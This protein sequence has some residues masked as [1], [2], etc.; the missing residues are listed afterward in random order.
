[1]WFDVPGAGPVLQPRVP[2][3]IFTGIVRI[4]A[5]EAAVNQPVADLEHIAPPARAP[6]GIAGASFSKIA[7]AIS[8]WSMDGILEHPSPV[9]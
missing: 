9:A 8:G 6:F 5:D 1:L 4:E 7:F 3:R 2:R